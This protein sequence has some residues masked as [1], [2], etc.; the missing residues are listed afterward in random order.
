MHIKYRCFIFI[1]VVF[2]AIGCKKEKL[3][4]VWEIN[5]NKTVVL[6]EINLDTIKL[7]KIEASY[8]GDIKLWTDSIYFIDKR[9]CWVFSFDKDG[10][11][12][13]RMLGQG[14]GPSELNTGLIDCHTRLSNGDH[15]IVGSGN[16]CHLF[17]KN[18]IRKKTFLIDKGDMRKKG[19][20]ASDFGIY[21]LMYPKLIFKNNGDKIY[22][23]Q[24]SEYEGYNVVNNP[25]KYFRECRLLSEMKLDD[26]KV[27][28]MYGRYSTYYADNDN[29]KQ[30]ALFSFDI[31]ENGNFLISFE[32]DSLIYEYDNEFNPIEAFG[33]SGENMNIKYKELNSLKEFQKYYLVERE[34]KGYY[35]WI[36]YIDELDMLFRSYKKG[37][38]SSTD[39]LQIYKSNTMIA[40]VEVPRNLKVIGFIDPY[41]YASSTI[42][43]ENEEMKVYR[44]TVPKK[45][46]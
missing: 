45:N 31:K 14:R 7:D 22:F 20:D 43:E 24:F 27:C 35:D 1:I 19:M 30:V 32:A 13:K 44:F 33:Y 16:D 18:F 3:N 25:S 8:V 40:D 21:T 4:I 17:D 23:N 29:V 42:D 38:N 6:N 34:T 36:E 41:V 2:L 15:L 46:N 10:H 37:D 5:N 11:F 9:F 12:I 39:G 28:E 26:G